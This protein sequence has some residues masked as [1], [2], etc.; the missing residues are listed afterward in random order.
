MLSEKTHNLFVVGDDDQSI[1]GFRGASPGIMKQFITDYKETITIRLVI[2]YRSNQEII[3]AAGDVIKE[4]QNRFNKTIIASNEGS[5]KIG[6]YFKIT[7]LSNHRQELNYVCDKIKKIKQENSRK[8]IA[9]ICRTNEEADHYEAF[10]KM[11]KISCYRKKTGICERHF[12]IKDMSAVFEIISADIKR[13][14]LLV[15]LNIMDIKIDR[16]Y[17]EQEYIDLFTIE[18]RLKENQEKDSI[19]F[20]SL[21]RLINK[22]SSMAPFSVMTIIRKGMGYEKWL[23][24]KA[25]EDIELFYFWISILDMLTKEAKNYSS[26]SDYLSFLNNYQNENSYNSQS[27]DG[28]ALL[29]LHAS[30]GLEYD[31]V[32]IPH[33]NEG[34]I[35]QGKALKKEAEEEERRL[36]YVG[37]T[38]AKKALE[39][40]YVSGTKEHP[41]LN[42]RFISK[43]INTY[44]SISSSASSTNS[45][46]S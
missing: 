43:L 22:I 21:V 20:S 33:C 45:S 19:K 37:M 11:N 36:L 18:K 23:R 13:A 41:R 4:N 14:N 9:V 5:V 27:K 8:Q 3:N 1:Y 34:N 44:S 24:K 17:L 46:N 7:Q 15:I 25:G 6:E 12:I 16:I 38:R 31:Y 32:I 2:N 42:S 35:P 39:L 30:K 29:T 40:L 26:I 28:V 10:L